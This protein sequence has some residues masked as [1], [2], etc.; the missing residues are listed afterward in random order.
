MRFECILPLFSVLLF[1]ADASPSPAVDTLLAKQDY[2]GANSLLVHHLD[3][4]PN[5]N[6]A[7]YMLIAVEQTRILD[8]ESYQLDAGPLYKKADSVN[9]VLKAR[10]PKFKGRDS[11]QCLFYIASI[12]GYFSV[13]QAKTGEL[14]PAVKNCIESVTLLNNVIK[15]DSNYNEAYMG[16]G[17]FHYYLDKSFKWLS[18]GDANGEME[19]INKLERA[20]L[21][22]FPYDFAARN[23]LCWIYIDQEKY[24]AADSIAGKVLSAY[25][26]NTIFLR[27]RCL[28]LL[29]EK[30]YPEAI[31]SGEK[32]SR[33]SLKRNPENWSDLVLASYVISSANDELGKSKEACAAADYILGMKIPEQYRQMG[34]IRKNLKRIQAIRKKC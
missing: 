17:I 11:L 31:A 20:T 5:D 1:S 30:K 28:S 34:H 15:L 8:Y 33:S 29:R 14:F 18:F 3:S 9:A 6:T 12:S 22:K 25:P 16:I 21:A 4:F 19:G 27:I 26:D 7:L 32:L 2:S 24:R 10:L 13:L 23:S